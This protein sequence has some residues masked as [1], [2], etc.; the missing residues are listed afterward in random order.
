MKREEMNKK[1]NL[2]PCM[3]TTYV[4][5]FFKIQKRILGKKNANF[6]KLTNNNV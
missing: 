2:D 6:V 5:I 3:S 1:G 4:D